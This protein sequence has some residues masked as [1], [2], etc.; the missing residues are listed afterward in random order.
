LRFLS[1]HTA[2][3]AERHIFAMPDEPGLAATF[4]ERRFRLF[5]PRFRFRH[6]A[7]F[8]SAYVSFITPIASQPAPCRR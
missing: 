1:F 4:S 7:I 3:A 6:Y 2:F 8:D 5:S